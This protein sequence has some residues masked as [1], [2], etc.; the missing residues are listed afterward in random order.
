MVGQK[1]FKLDR[2]L[3]E[4]EIAELA[5]M[6]SLDE[7]NV[8]DFKGKFDGWHSKEFYQGLL[9]GYR[10]MRVLMETVPTAKIVPLTDQIM[11]F[12]AD[13]ITKLPKVNS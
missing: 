3:D 11:I 5:K 9:T 1:P 13:Y 10:N 6:I 12:I 8:E 7:S 4:E 2:R